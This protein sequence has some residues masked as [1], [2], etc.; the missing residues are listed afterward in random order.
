[1]FIKINNKNSISYVLASSIIKVTFSNSDE[2]KVFC[3]IITTEQVSGTTHNYDNR[4]T[5]TTSASKSIRVFQET[6]EESYNF[7]KEMVEGK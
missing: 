2:G 3:D 7:L 5:Q 4:S 6:S 1:M